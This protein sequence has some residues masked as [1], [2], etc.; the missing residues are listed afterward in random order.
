[1]RRAGERGGERRE[2]RERTRMSRNEIHKIGDGVHW[3][4]RETWMD[5]KD[6]KGR[7]CRLYLISDE[8]CEKQSF[9]GTLK[10]PRDC[11]YSI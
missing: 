5:K 11:L 1:V 8:G 6:V 4:R 7:L 10:E 9:P 2:R 3:D